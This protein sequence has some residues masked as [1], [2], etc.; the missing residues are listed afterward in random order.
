MELTCR[1]SDKL[2]VEVG[3]SCVKD[4]TKFSLIKEKNQYKLQRF[5]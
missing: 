3:T 2:A 5:T 4:H 1:L